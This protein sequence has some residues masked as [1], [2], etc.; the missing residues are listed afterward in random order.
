MTSITPYETDESVTYK[1]DTILSLLSAAVWLIDDFT[2]KEAIGR[3]R[4]KIKETGKEAIKNPSG[5][6]I[7]IDRGSY[8]VNIS[9]DKYFPLPEDEVKID[10]PFLIFNTD[11]PPTGAI[12]TKL[13]DVSN[14][15][16]LDTV[17]FYNRTG[18][19]E[20]RNIISIDFDEKRISWEGGLRYDYTSKGSSIL[21][22]KKEHV[23]SVHLKPIPFYPFPY[24]ATL[25][26]GLIIDSS[27]NPVVDANIS[28][29]SAARQDL[30]TNSDKNGEF[31]LYFHDVKNNEKI[32][33]A[34]TKNG[35]TK[36][37]DTNL[38]EGKTKY[39]GKIL[40]QTG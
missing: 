30:E 28:V 8:T 13:K 23:I 19:I 26:R 32:S 17:V 4:V 18:D 1:G 20:Q 22:L 21:A 3:I 11:G 25:V 9:T 40:F 6:Y 38:E 16:K 33:I 5:Y 15:Q 36:S 2:K 7:F 24:N 14:L 35:K 12:S 34:I 39:L 29:E 27:S 37:T 10:I 31:V